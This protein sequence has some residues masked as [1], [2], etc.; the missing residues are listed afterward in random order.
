MKL[1]LVLIIIITSVLVSFIKGVPEN[2]KGQ[3]PGLANFPTSFLLLEPNA[4]FV[5]NHES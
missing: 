2:I 5:D 4:A 3:C 1:H